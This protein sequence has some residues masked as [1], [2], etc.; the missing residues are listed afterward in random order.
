MADQLTQLALFT[1]SILMMFNIGE[2]DVANFSQFPTVMGQVG[3]YI[4]QDSVQTFALSLSIIV[5]FFVDVGIVKGFAAF[6][7]E[8]KEWELAA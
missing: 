8:V 7:E 5:G 2:E 6:K 1:Q 3:D 4:Q